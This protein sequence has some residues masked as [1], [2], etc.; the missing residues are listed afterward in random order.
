M[1]CSITEFQAGLLWGVQ[2]LAVMAMKPVMGRLSD[3]QGR[4]PLLFWGMFVCAIPFALIPWFRDYW[5]LM[6][7]AACFGLGE[8][9]VTSSAAALVADFCKEAQLG[10]AMGAFGTL[11]DIGHA[12]GPLLAGLLIGLTGGED[13]RA[14]FGL[15]AVLLVIAALASGGGE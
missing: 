6:V 4:A 2:I 14:S 15:V 12:S 13:Y 1:I 11:F 8:A 5:I 7:L 9:M 10:S 3:R